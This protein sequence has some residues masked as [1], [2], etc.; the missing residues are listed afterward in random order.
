MRLIA[1]FIENPVKVAVGVLLLVLFGAITVFRMPIE[2]A[3]QVEQPWLTVFTVWPG[4]GPEEIEREIVYEQEK[5]LKTVPG[6]RYI[7]SESANSM[8]SISMGFAA[9]ADMNEALVKVNALL[10]QVPQY[11]E[12]AREPTIYSGTDTSST[13]AVFNL[14]P[15]PPNDEQLVA[16]GRKHPERGSALDSIR[17]ASVPTLVLERI[18]TLAEEFP[19]LRELLP[20]VDVLTCTRFAEDRVAAA[21]ARVPGVARVWLWGGK[22]D[23][24][25][26]I[27]DPVKL[28]SRGLTIA[29]IRRA[30][31]QQ[32]HDTP[33][34]GLDDGKRRFDVRTL[35]RYTSPQQIADEVVATTDGAPIYVGDV[36]EVQLGH[37]TDLD[38]AAMH[39]ATTSLRLGVVK[40]PGHNLLE[41]MQGV[42]QVRD[43]LNEGPLKSSQLLLYQSFD[44]TVYVNSAIGLVGKNVLLGGLFT[45]AVL[46]LFLR[47]VRLTLIVAV[48]IPTSII[49]TFL[50]LGLLGRSL[51]VVSLAGMSFAVGMLVDNAVVVLENIF[52]HHQ[53]GA[54]PTEAAKR[55]TAFICDRVVWSGY[56]GIQLRG[57]ER[58]WLG[59]CAGPRR[60]A[61]GRIGIVD[62]G[63]RERNSGCRGVHYP[64]RHLRGSLGSLES[65][66]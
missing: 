3:P 25:R 43:E 60:E 8:A 17:S 63:I 62:E 14:I 28:A 49:G 15:R 23:E 12:T 59:Q 29:D 21:M 24:M 16:F 18:E 52:R 20:D 54:S 39:F 1:T 35:G 56:R 4:A 41:V 65:I 46:L 42:R 45:V 64:I 55:G 11:R 66:D 48:T 7:T 57:M 50:V 32:N 9:D 5:Q 33:A 34:G 10:Q 27:V 53:H 13:I 51:N 58:R 44:D 26:V 38:S 47:S 22:R 37:R 2:L 40:E 31:R 30:L 6:M 36:A 19:I 61:S